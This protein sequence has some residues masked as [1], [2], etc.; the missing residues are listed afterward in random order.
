MRFLTRLFRARASLLRVHPLMR[1]ARVSTSL[2]LGVAGVAL[3]ILSPVNILGD[4]PVIGFLDDALLLTM[5]ATWFV[6]LA[7]RQIE[8][9]A[10]AMAVAPLAARSRG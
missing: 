1:D 2:K 7:T 6:K 10:M 5:L 8:R 9:P 4:I 3:V